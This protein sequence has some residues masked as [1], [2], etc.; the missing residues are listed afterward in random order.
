MILSNLPQMFTIKFPSDFFYSEL[1]EKWG[2]VI[3]RLKVPY[4]SIED[5]MNAQIQSVDFP[6]INLVNTEQQHGQYEI[7]Y[8]GGKELEP[9]I[10]KFITVKFKL[11]E[12]Y[13]TYWILFD[14]IDTYLKYSATNHKPCFMDPIVL[15]FTNNPGFGLVQFEFK[16]IVPENLS[17]LPLSYMSQPASFHT[18]D[19]RLKFS[20]YDI[21]YLAYE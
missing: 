16:Q 20:R 10:D 18:I 3:K 5:F 14:Q 15:T 11:T 19:W 9:L 4:E 12:S 8:P 21:K 1:T 7:T 17:N 2:D 6:G 13:L